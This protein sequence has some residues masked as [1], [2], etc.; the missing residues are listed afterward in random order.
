MTRNNPLPPTGK[1]QQRI[2]GRLSIESE[3]GRRYT[4]YVFE[5][6]VVSPKISHDQQNRKETL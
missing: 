1:P 3:V 2:T 5:R 4:Q 6:G